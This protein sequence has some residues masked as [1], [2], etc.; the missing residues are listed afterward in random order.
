VG[1]TALLAG[2]TADITLGDP[3]RFHPVAGFGA[4]AGAL[5]RRLY[6]PTRRRGALATAIMV[7]GA[8]LGAEL[9]ARRVGRPLTLAALTWTAL[10]GRSLRREAG[11]VEAL[12]GR[13]ELE[14][15]R[16]GLRSLCGRDA[17]RLQAPAIRAGVIESLAEN[18]SD[19]VVGA[20][21]WGALG[22]PAGAAGYRAANT[23]DAIWGHHNDRFEHFGWAAARLD[24]ALNWLPARLTAALACGA[25]P[26]V[27]GAPAEAL[28]VLRRDSRAHPSPNAG[29][30]ESAFAG[31]LGLTLGGPVAYAGRVENRPWLGDG[32]TP[33][34]Q[35]VARAGR[36]SAL[37]SAA[38]ALLCAAVAR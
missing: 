21:L 11:A 12:L 5:E 25:A 29:V 2:Y 9:A 3:K 37:V 15:A 35:D 32:R 6:A 10:G 19:A 17:S 24:D 7:G 22:G 38:A 36:L 14:S 30:V 18:T 28:A 26:L 20:L 8:A 23:L 33:G 4:L 13:E 34:P 27:G 1:A 16:H 31:A